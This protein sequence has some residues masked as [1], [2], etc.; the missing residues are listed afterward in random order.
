[1]AAVGRNLM[2]FRRIDHYKHVV[3]A[4]EKKAEEKKATDMCKCPACGGVLTY[5]QTVR[6]K[7]WTVTCA[8]C[9]KSASSD[10]GALS[11]KVD[12]YSTLVDICA[13]A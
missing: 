9:A 10:L 13:K 2:K 3:V 12:A 7:N 4:V 11:E 5:T 1:M 6:T 8:K